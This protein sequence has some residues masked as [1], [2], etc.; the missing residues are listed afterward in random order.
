MRR[1]SMKSLMIAGAVLLASTAVLA[2]GHG[3]GGMGPR[4]PGCMG[5]GPGGGMGPGFGPRA[6]QEL[7]LSAEQ[8]KQGEELKAKL[9][10]QIAPV[11][12]QLDAKRGELQALWSAANP[13]RRAILAKQVEMDSL[14]DGLR[15]AH[16]D[17]RLAMMKLLTPEQRAKA[18]AHRGGPGRGQG[19]HGDGGGFGGGEP[20]MG[21]GPG[22]DCP[23][24]W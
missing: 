7:G 1:L 12:A 13:D 5:G 8:R 17:F 23:R 4:G 9:E 11:R 21:P 18:A 24:P 20:G 19:P 6:A 15:T 3:R 2:G 16:V 22:G 14:R 10:A